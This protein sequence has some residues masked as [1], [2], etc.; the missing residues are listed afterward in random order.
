M[1]IFYPSV[2]FLA[3]LVFCSCKQHDTLFRLV[4]SSSSGI[5]FNNKIVET[6]SVNPIDLTNVYNG[7]GVG[8]G[9]FNNDGLQDI[10]FTGNLVPNKL[11]LNKGH[12]KF[13]DITM[14]AGV[15]GQGKWCRGVAVVDINNDGWLDMY[16]CVSMDKDPGKRKNILYINKG[17]DKNKI[18]VFKDEAA[19]YGLDDTTHSTM[20]NFF[21]YDNDGDLDMYLV[22]NQILPDV[23]PA[24]FKRQVTDGSFPSTGRLYR[25][26]ADSSLHHPVFRNVTKEAGVTIEG[27]GHAATI[28]DINQ[29]GWKD[30]FVSNDFLP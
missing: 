25:N 2:I 29:D 3:T 17:L 28:A 21:D 16:V 7:G 8:V 13:E 9:D 14:A 1:K 23:N 20:A 26:D 10:Y 22:V 27:Y 6:D 15:K 11:Y 30:I 5:T 19:S 18:P 4:S 24:M 12:L